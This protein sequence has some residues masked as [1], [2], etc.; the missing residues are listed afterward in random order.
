MSIEEANSALRR[1][2]NKTINNIFDANAID[3]SCK[4]LLSIDVRD[5]SCSRSCCSTKDR[6]LSLS[7]N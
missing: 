3:R 5:N 1:E 4:V 7:N 6:E 2:Y